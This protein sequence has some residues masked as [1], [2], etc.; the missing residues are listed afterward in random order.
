MT[1]TKQLRVGQQVGIKKRYSA[2]STVISG[3]V[4][5]GVI[6]ELMTMVEGAEYSLSAD[7]DRR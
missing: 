4:A 3:Q 6:R 1:A 7:F 5:D 2:D